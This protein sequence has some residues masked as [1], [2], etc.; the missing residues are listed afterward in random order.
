MKTKQYFI[1]KG[2]VKKSDNK[3]LELFDAACNDFTKYKDLKPTAFVKL[4][5]DEYQR[6]EKGNNTINGYVFEYI[7]AALL[8][9]KNIFPFYMQTNVTFIPGIKYDFLLYSKESGPIVL[10]TKT[11]LRER[12]RQADLEALVLRNVHRQAKSYLL[13]LNKEEYD[14]LSKEE[15]IGLND[16]FYCVDDSFDNLISDLAK[17]IFIEPE[18][19]NILSSTALIK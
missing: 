5:W 14:A 19:V 6:Q 18:P 10:S 15:L 7:I 16:V 4:V 8:I 17:N 12:F 1:E 13:T 3:S 2:I 11:S 9:N